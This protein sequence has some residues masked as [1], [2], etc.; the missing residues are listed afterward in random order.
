MGRAVRLIDRFHRALMRPSGGRETGHGVLIVAAG[1]LGDTVIL[2]RVLPRLC[3]LAAAGEPVSVLLRSDAAK[4]AFLFPAGVEVL[5][6]DF[7][8]LDRDI[9]YRWQTL[10]LVSERRFRIAISADFLRH[11]YLDEPLLLAANAAQTI[12][13][14]ARPW[15]KYDNRLRENARHFS[16]V[17][18]SG[19]VHVDKF[20]RLWRFADWVTDESAPLPKLSLPETSLPPPER[21]DRPLVVIQPFSAVRAKQPSAGF[22][23]AL[24]DAL[25][26]DIDVAITGAPGDLDRNPEFRDLLERSNTRFD[27][28]TFE[29][30]LPRLRAARL[31]I[32][33]DTALMHLAAVAGAPTLCLASA[34]YVGEIVPYADEIAPDNVRF[35]YHDMPCRGCLGDCS[36]PLIDGRFACVDGISEQDAVAELR[37]ILAA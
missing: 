19:P 35:V 16:R 1:G 12:A 24:V 21:T 3:S 25:P 31:V 28:S 33:V 34:A 20:V 27:A 22:F 9:V 30:L 29:E 4:M 2:S 6:V 37:G 11:P 36:Q 26:A 8:R 7:R 23:R 10:R 17:F 5:S 32:S 14:K 15:S 13:M 18:D